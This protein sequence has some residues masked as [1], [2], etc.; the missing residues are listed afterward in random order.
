MLTPLF[1]PAHQLLKQRQA[2]QRPIAS[3]PLPRGWAAVETVGH[4]LPRGGHRMHMRP[5][6]QNSHTP[7]TH[8]GSPGL[9]LTQRVVIL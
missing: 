9:A 2:D 1:H 3:V 5:N 8:C 6:K 7:S 4:Q